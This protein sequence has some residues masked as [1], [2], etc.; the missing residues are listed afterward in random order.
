MNR[1]LENYLS[2]SWIVNYIGDDLYHI[3]KEIDPGVTVFLD[4]EAHKDFRVW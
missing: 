1:S 3:F 4:N 2:I